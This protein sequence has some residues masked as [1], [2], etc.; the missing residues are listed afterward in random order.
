MNNHSEATYVTV[1]GLLMVGVTVVVAGPWGL[2]TLVAVFSQLAEI[3]SRSRREVAGRRDHGAELQ[4]PPMRIVDPTS[5]YYVNPEVIAAAAV[6]SDDAWR[7]LLAETA[8]DLRAH[9]AQLVRA[10]GLPIDGR[11]LF[12]RTLL[13]AFDRLP[14]S[15]EPVRNFAAW[16]H[17]LARN[18]AV[19]ECREA[20]RRPR[21]EFDADALHAVHDTR[22]PDEHFR[23]EHA[24]IITW[25]STLT[26][27]E[28]AVLLVRH[29]GGL[30]WAEVT[31]RLN[32]QFG[33]PDH[34]RGYWRRVRD[35]A[36]DK[37]RSELDEKEA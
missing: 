25:L 26:E 33:T 9:C 17:V 7:L 22:T 4:E 8:D 6:G 30:R 32:D 21:T 23:I 35:R 36:L 12:A 28:R 34:T 31:R 18:L 14:E 29:I 1:I 24:H 27:E 20:Q 19:D 2:L 11:E 3:I 5:P 15:T 16:V 37:G 10:Y 13:K